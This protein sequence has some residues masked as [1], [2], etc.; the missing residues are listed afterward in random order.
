M[1][2]FTDQVITQAAV[3][4]VKAVKC[5]RNFEQIEDIIDQCVKDMMKKERE[6]LLD[7]ST[8]I[9]RSEIPR[10]E[11]VDENGLRRFDLKTCDYQGVMINKE[12]GFWVPFNDVVNVYNAKR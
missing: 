11:C 9:E 4:L 10:F 6:K 2:H 7:K 5:N 12:D 3:V 8:T 1:G